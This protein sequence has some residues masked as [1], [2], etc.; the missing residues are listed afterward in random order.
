MEQ[1]LKYIQLVVC[2]RFRSWIL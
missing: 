1:E 2:T